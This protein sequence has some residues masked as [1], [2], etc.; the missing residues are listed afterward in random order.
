MESDFVTSQRFDDHMDNFSK[1]EKRVDGINI[2]LGS[3]V[4]WVVFWSIF[5]VLIGLS[6]TVITA[7]YVSIKDVQKTGTE[8]QNAVFYI[9]GTLD[10]S[11]I[12]K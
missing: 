4:S 7:L 9:K 1:L 5:T 11:E 8:T 10:N 2:E 12:T 3:K 6:A